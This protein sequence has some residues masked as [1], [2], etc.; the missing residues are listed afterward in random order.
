MLIAVFMIAPCF[1]IF[2]GCSLFGKN[3]QPKTF[4]TGE[5]SITLTNEF[6]EKNPQIGY[7][8]MLTSDDVMFFVSS[9]S[10]ETLDNAV[11]DFDSMTRS[12]YANLVKQNGNVLL[13]SDCNEEGFVA[14]RY[15]QNVSGQSYY[16]KAYVFKTQD[17][18]WLC[19][20]A[21]FN[22][23]ETSKEKFLPWAQTITFASQEV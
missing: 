7:R 1:A 19:Q 16:Y 2:A 18:F 3:V 6:L 14:F 17:E 15:W 13:A 10:K 4:T 12:E 5:M 8:M 23:D 20:F 11:Y 22:T 9:E 21:C